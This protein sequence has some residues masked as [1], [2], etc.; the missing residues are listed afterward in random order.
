MQIF[1]TGDAMIVDR[2]TSS[3]PVSDF[4]V[5]P[6]SNS[7]FI[8]CSLQKASILFVEE[9]SRNAFNRSA[10]SEPQLCQQYVIHLGKVLYNDSIPIQ[11][12]REIQ[13][14]WTDGADSKRSVDF[15]F[16]NNEYSVDTKP[17]FAMEAKRLAG[18]TGDRE[19]E[20]VIGSNRN[21]GIERFKIGAHGN[22]LPECGMLGFI[23]I[24]NARYWHTTINKWIEDLADEITWY[25]SEVLSA[26]T[27]D[28]ICAKSYS[29]VVRENSGLRLLHFWI[30]LPDTA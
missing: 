21:G 17:L 15:A 1:L 30:T 6:K 20:Y 10:L 3:Q 25:K 8:E 2:I 24:E 19:K 9:M 18:F 4:G 7:E 11:V 23:E 27:T 5:T 29:N 12:Q 28:N 14:I 26:I 16:F 22:E 13:D